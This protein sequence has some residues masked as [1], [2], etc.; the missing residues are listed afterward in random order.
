M[1]PLRLRLPMGSVGSSLPSGLALD[2]PAASEH[3]HRLLA[4]AMAL[5][6]LMRSMPAPLFFQRCAATR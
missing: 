2:A 1:S 5:R 4:L 6:A 3:R